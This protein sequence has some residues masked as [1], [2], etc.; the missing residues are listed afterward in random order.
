MHANHQT[1]QP[2]YLQR[3]ILAAETCLPAVRF[4]YALSMLPWHSL[5]GYRLA[6]G[7]LSKAAGATPVR[8]TQ[9]IVSQHH[10]KQ[11]LLVMIAKEQN[12]GHG[13]CTWFCEAQ[14][15][16]PLPMHLCI[17]AQT[18]ALWESGAQLSVFDVADLHDENACILVEPQQSFCLCCRCWTVA[19]HDLCWSAP[20]FPQ[21]CFNAMAGPTLSHDKSQVQ[22]AT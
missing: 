15:N 22:E 14:H 6:A 1:P 19:R 2:H 16:S 11:H 13:T 9:P 20:L 17:L 3:G 5:S 18:K 21:H 4:A 10:Y 8:H 7:G 12:T